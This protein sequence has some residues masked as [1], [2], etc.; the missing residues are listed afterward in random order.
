MRILI[1]AAYYLPHVGGYITDTHEL[2]K[3]LVAHGHEV[4]VLT[5][6]MTKQPD[7]EVIDGVTV[8][9]VSC[10][11]LLR[12]QYPIPLPSSRLRSILRAKRYNVVSTQTRFFPTSLLG[13]VY[14]WDKRIPHI[15]TE[16]GAF[17][18]SV[19]NKL[20]DVLSRL[21]D[22]TLGT[23]T[24]RLANVCVGTS[25]ASCAFLKH[26]GVRRKL[27]RISLGVGGVFSAQVRNS[28]SL[29]V[30]YIGRLIYGKGVQDL[31]SA[32][33][34]VSSTIP[35]ARLLIV[36]D[37]IYRRKLEEQANGGR[38]QFCGEKTHQEV[39]E[40]LSQ[41]SV[42]VNPSY[43]EG[44]PSSV[45]EAAAV[46]LPVVAT[47]VGGTREL[48]VDKHTGYLVRLGD[49]KDMA[50]KITRLLNNPRLAETM[51]KAGKAKMES[52]YQWPS[53]IDKYLSVISALVKKQ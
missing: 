49:K 13:A 47:D 48:V 21:Y 32:F 27:I 52:E 26:L 25:E 14:A 33:K 50:R 15:H 2:A 30:I 28:H 40:A 37:G 16:R 46:G 34:D 39:A 31:I 35:A 51:G 44:M 19:K 24:V 7:Q 6:N 5:C 10:W 41:A 4:D 53:V 42:F 36:G 22:H 8:Y 1:F 29:T 20:V 9:R 3:G 12:G 11:N 38:V 43:S 18:S 45:A 17:H 23:L